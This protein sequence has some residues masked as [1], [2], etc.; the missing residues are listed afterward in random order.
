MLRRRC[1]EQRMLWEIGSVLQ[2]SP[3]GIAVMPY[4]ECLVEAGG[5]LKNDLMFFLIF[6]MV[7]PNY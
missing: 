6:G 4:S 1:A 5:S 7:I 3:G 2:G